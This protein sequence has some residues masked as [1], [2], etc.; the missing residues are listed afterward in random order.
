MTDPPPPDESG[1]PS[2]PKHPVEVYLPPAP[3][4]PAAPAA[5]AES[6]PRRDWLQIAGALGV[7]AALLT[8]HLWVGILQGSTSA[9]ADDVKGL[10]QD[11]KALVERMSA[12]DT[13]LSMVEL[14][15]GTMEKRA[16]E[17]HAELK[18][19]LEG[20]GAAKGHP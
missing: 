1:K 16:D 9:T 5:P 6:A 18:A 13:R 4:Q 15:L 3:K 17:R 7:F 2:T 20:R 8:L 14:R 11:V 19:L 12:I 10:K